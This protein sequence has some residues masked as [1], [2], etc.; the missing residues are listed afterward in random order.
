MISV[1][2]KAQRLQCAQLR[3]RVRLFRA[4]I[5]AVWHTH[6]VGRRESHILGHAARHAQDCVGVDV[7]EPGRNHPALA[8]QDAGCRID[9]RGGKLADGGDPAIRDL[10]PRPVQKWA[11]A[12]S[13][14]IAL[15]PAMI[16]S[17]TVAISRS[18]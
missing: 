3:E 4:H 16:R 7:N 14:V 10:D 8:I 18:P 5:V 15:A 9:P 1:E 12:G 11:C 2:P 17:G 6:R 13:E